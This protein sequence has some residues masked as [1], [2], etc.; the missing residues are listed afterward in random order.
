[1]KHKHKFLITIDTEGDNLW[2]RPQK[3]TTKNA[4]FLPRFQLLCESYDFKPTYFVNFEMAKCQFFRNFGQNII[5][6]KSG[7][8]G[9]HLHSWNSPPIIPL[10][11]NDNRYQPFLT[12]FPESIMRNKI[13]YMKTLLE[14]TFQIDV[15]SHRA[16]R[17]AFNKLYAKILIENKFHSDSSVTPH[18]NWKHTKG[19]PEG[20]GGPNY[21]HYPDNAYFIN[22][23]D[24]S[25]PGSSPLL[26]VPITIIPSKR[27]FID[28]IRKPFT[29]FFGDENIISN[30]FRKYYILRPNGKDLK[31]LK[32]IVEQAITEKR[33]YLHLMLHSSE[34]MP[35]GSPTF[36]NEKSISSLYQDLG[37]LFEFISATFEGAT[38]EEYYK[39]KTQK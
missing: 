1:M 11:R 37:V 32:W 18:I 16:G 24:I 34:L 9:M 20:N 30:L 33:E 2:A 15:F 5:A 7:E 21:I 35:G 27:P 8:I 12:E 22:V 36:P 4:R 17:W 23:E 28:K 39:I 25:I 31:Q 14:E 10:T 38:L 13:V 3:I 6:K 29:R 26:E 19:N